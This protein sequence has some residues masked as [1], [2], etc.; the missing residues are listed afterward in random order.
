MAGPRE[1]LFVYG[2]LRADLAH[3]MARAVGKRAEL[4]GRAYFRG[5]LFDLGEYP[6]AVASPSPSDRVVGELHRIESG[7]E[8]ALLAQLDR[9]EGWNPDRPGESEFMRVRAR[10]ESEAGDRVEAWVYTYNRPTPRRA[11]I[12]SGDYRRRDAT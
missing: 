11:R 7:Q 5:K 3:P 4:V 1:F 10:V 8:A 2:T 9:Y 12:A 6:G